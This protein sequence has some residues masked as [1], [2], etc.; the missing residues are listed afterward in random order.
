MSG[1]EWEDEKGQEVPPLVWLLATRISLL[2]LI[3]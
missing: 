2:A 1:F 3:M